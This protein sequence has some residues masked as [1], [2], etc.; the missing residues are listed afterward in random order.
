MTWMVWLTDLIGSG[1]KR[2]VLNLTTFVKQVTHCPRS[3]QIWVTF[4]IKGSKVFPSVLRT[5]GRGGGALAP[6]PVSHFREQSH[7]LPSGRVRVGPGNGIPQTLLWNNESN[8]W[9]TYAQKA[10]KK[11]KAEQNC[12]ISV[13]THMAGDCLVIWFVTCLPLGL[14]LRLGVG[15]K[16]GYWLCNQSVA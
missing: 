9:Q 11:S 5:P 14:G 3:L 10:H 6:K 4:P 1:Y 15:F 12:S 16:L 13:T 7:S 8:W 2:R